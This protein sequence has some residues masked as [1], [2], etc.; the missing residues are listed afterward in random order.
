MLIH[1]PVSP[2]TLRASIPDSLEL[3]V[4]QGSAYLTLIPFQILGNR[5]HG[6]PLGA[7]HDFL[8]LNARTYV[9]HG[10]IPGIYFFSLDASSRLAVAFARLLVG[11]PYR[12]AEMEMKRFGERGIEY[13]SARK[14]QPAFLFARY[15]IGDPLETPVPE[16][17]PHFLLERYAL[18]IERGPTLW[19]QQVRHRP[20]RPRGVDVLDL[21][22]A[23]WEADGVP[24][25]W[26]APELAHYQDEL[27]V[28]IFAP[29]PVALVP[30]GA[31]LG[32]GNMPKG[33]LAFR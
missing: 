7:G 28:E 31:P 20:Y 2:A 13:R 11:L 23:I 10:D 15:Q 30:S 1:W 21:E 17:L 8:E 9:R 24:G 3:D 6:L 33:P 19:R 4:F 25:G 27:E 12:Y 18:F 16:T 22:H 14:S 26:G 32:Q 29:A 5:P